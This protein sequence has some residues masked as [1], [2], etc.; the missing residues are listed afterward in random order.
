[1]T[2][3]AWDSFAVSEKWTMDDNNL[4][5]LLF[6]VL[7]FFFFQFTMKACVFVYKTIGLDSYCEPLTCR[8]IRKKDKSNLSPQSCVSLFTDF[9]TVLKFCLSDEKMFDGLIC[10]QKKKTPRSVFTQ[11]LC[12]QFLSEIVFLSLS[13]M[14]V[15]TRV[16]LSKDSF[17]L[18]TVSLLLIFNT[19]KIDENIW[20]D[21]S[22]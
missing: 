10:G 7:F 4:L 18:S 20:L 5:K 3:S 2:I 1:M 15:H 16:V 11:S 22:F 19:N 14:F 13:Q 12:L 21:F 6:F 17:L 9:W 8:G